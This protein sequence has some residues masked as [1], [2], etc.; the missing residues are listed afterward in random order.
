MSDREIME[1]FSI[2]AAI[3]KLGNLT[4]VPITNM[5]G[6]E[7]C[8]LGNDYGMMT[9]SFTVL[10]SRASSSSF[11]SEL[12]D[13]CSL[14]RA[15]FESL[16]TGLLT[17]TV[18]CRN[19]VLLTDLSSI[20]AEAS[21]DSLTRAMYGRLFTW[22]MNRTN[23]AIKVVEPRKHKVIALLDM[24]GFETAGSGVNGFQQLVINYANEKLHQLLIATTLHKEQEEY[25]KEGFEWQR[26]DFFD[27]SIIC[28]LIE[29]SHHDG[30]LFILD[31]VTLRKHQ[32]CDTDH[33]LSLEEL[34]VSRAEQFVERL[35]S[36]GGRANNPHLTFP[37]RSALEPDTSFQ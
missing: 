31:E 25:V 18:E 32:S 8:S 1:I 36:N 10:A 21:R 5:D 23:E 13:I 35:R 29:K 30:M 4:F 33:D 28:N 7:G 27:N 15:D 2:I 6:T 20:E 17:R 37:E 34:R 22:L 24:F 11:L 3:L 19:E 16:Q 14:L 12:Y 9:P 26:L